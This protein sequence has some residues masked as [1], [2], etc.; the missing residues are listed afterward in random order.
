MAEQAAPV[1][2]AAVKE[3]GTAAKATEPKEK[4]TTSKKGFIST[5][6]NVRGRD[7]DGYAVRLSEDGKTADVMLPSNKMVE[8][9]KIKE[10]DTG[11]KYVVAANGAT[12]FIP[13]AE[14]KTETPKQQPKAEAKT[15]AKPET[16]IRRRLDGIVDEGP[17][18][19]SKKAIEL[20]NI[21]A[22]SPNSFNGSE[23]PAEA[24]IINPQGTP[25]NRVIEKAYKD[26]EITAEEMDL[27][28][29]GLEKTKTRYYAAKAKP[30]L[31]EFKDKVANGIRSAKLEEGLTG[32]NA[33]LYNKVLD[34][35]AKLFEKGMDAAIALSKALDT[36]LNQE[37]ADGRMTEA[38]A[39][40][41]KSKVLS[42]EGA[43]T[44]KSRPEV[45]G[46]KK[47]VLSTEAKAKAEMDTQKMSIDDILEAG[48]KAAEDKT[49][50][51]GRDARDFCTAIAESTE[52]APVLN[53]I[54]TAALVHHKA[55]IDEKLANLYEAQAKAIKDGDEDALVDIKQDIT[56]LEQQDLEYQITAAKT[57][58][59]QGL[60][61]FTRRFLL[62]QQYNLVQMIN[63]YKA[64]NDGEISKEMEEK[65]RELDAKY[66]ELNKKLEELE[67]RK[68]L[69]KVK[70]LFLILNQLVKIQ[71][72]ELM[73]KQFHLQTVR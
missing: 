38:E 48:K 71:K 33:A 39:D 30:G 44:T 22:S 35:A 5:K 70:K 11:R 23:K 20:K 61:L 40:A 2:K 17:N 53:A 63:K 59:E 8:G 6:G 10:T 56:I 12:V 14:A 29:D 37:V 68:R 58:Y 1:T 69:L 21:V 73:L 52:R 64:A 36:V 4:A 16:K 42:E 54:Q 32:L 43:T 57:A 72:K 24:G 18:K 49:T 7:I 60:S 27:L 25:M 50:F 62:D 31:E 51:N 3:E 67:S 9:L 45:S 41:E 19:S 46:I 65:F 66:R 47:E 55:Q 26:K 34:L 13:K 28:L 15:E